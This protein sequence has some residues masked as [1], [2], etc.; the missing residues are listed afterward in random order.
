M[1]NIQPPYGERVYMLAANQTDSDILYASTTIGLF[2][3]SD[4]GNNW[5]KINTR[6]LIGDGAVV[7]GL[8]LSPKGKTTYAFVI[9]NQGEDGFIIKSSDGAKTWTKT[10]GQIDG[11][12]YLGKFAFGKKGE[13][14]PR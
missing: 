14:M 12:K 10:D 6:E 4:Q 8:G 1:D 5:Q 11:A 3:S 2:K 9:S 7:T 13:F